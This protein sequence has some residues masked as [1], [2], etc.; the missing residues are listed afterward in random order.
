M[1]KTFLTILSL[2]ALLTATTST[3]SSHG[4][5]VL[6]NDNFDKE[7][8]KHQYLLV[9]FHEEDSEHNKVPHTEIASTLEELASLKTPV[10]V[11]KVEA[12]S[13]IQLLRKLKVS[14]F[15]TL[16]LFVKQVP[17]RFTGNIVGYEI[18]G[19]V[20]EKIARSLKELYGEI[21]LNLFAQQNEVFIAFL[22]VN[23][24]LFKIFETINL[25]NEDLPFTYCKTNDCFESQK[26]T[27]G[28]VV[29]LKHFDER[30]NVLTA[31]YTQEQLRD[32][33]KLNYLRRVLK[34]DQKTA[35]HIF[36][37]KNPAIIL[38]RDRNTPNT[39]D[40]DKLMELIA[41]EYKGF[42][43]V[44]ITGISEGFEK[45][46]A[47]Y[48][49]VREEDLPTVRIV[50]T[51]E[52]LVKY[53]LELEINHTNLK[54]FIGKW[55]IKL[56]KRTVKSEKVP[57]TQ[58]GPV[59]TLVGETFNEVVLDKTKDVLV[60]FVGPSCTACKHLES[61]CLELAQILK[62]NKNL[63]IAKMDGDANENEVVRVKSFPSLVFFKADNKFPDEYKGGNNI[64][65]LISFLKEKAHFPITE[66]DRDL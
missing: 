13:N 16:I 24:E 64:K 43:Q 36:A 28:S 10:K 66:D 48:I 55:K 44:V 1:L 60:L 18:L 37:R 65:E 5:L 54:D 8:T 59:Y 38:F 49:G 34:F 12:K 56:L 3:E 41:K 20:K 40:L 46:L 25:E 26:T 6:T 50:D 33:I 42:I 11:A 7:I 57:E 19:W 62:H 14:S 58:D 23:E 32:F 29:L 4:F 63:T 21:D 47:D 30:V 22:G 45:K 35:T 52:D 39:A 53:K 17:V 2:F 51:T 9:Q 15:P 27:N 61:L 31:P